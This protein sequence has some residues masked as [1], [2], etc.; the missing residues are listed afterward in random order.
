[1][2]NIIGPFAS[3]SGLGIA[4]RNIALVVA[5]RGLPPACSLLPSGSGRDRA[6]PPFPMTPPGAVDISYPNSLLIGGALPGPIG[7]QMAN[8]LKSRTRLGILAY[9]ELTELIEESIEY[10]GLADVLFAGSAF[11]RDVF[12]TY[13]PAKPCFELPCPVGALSSAGRPDRA[14]FGLPEDVPL[15]MVAFEP[16]SDLNRKNPEAAIRAFLQ[17]K[18]RG[19]A[20]LVLKLNWPPELPKD[21]TTMIFRQARELFDSA[22]QH[23]DIIGVEESLSYAD[24][25]E[26]YSCVDVIVSLH[27]SEGLGLVLLEGMLLRK[28]VIAT[29]Y[30]GNLAFMNRTYPGLVNYRLIAV[31]SPGSRYDAQYY[32]RPPVWADPDVEHASRLIERVLT[33]EDFARRLSREGEQAARSY[34]ERAERAEW[35]RHIASTGSQF[36]PRFAPPTYEGPRYAFGGQAAGRSFALPT[37]WSITGPKAAAVLGSS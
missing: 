27:R 25:L 7:I 17:C 23:P 9:W 3:E 22:R 11:T 34:V 6:V 35:I 20:K 15:V 4:A 36:N 37:S 5:R 14:R 26:L 32:A 1:M 29:A 28:P 19:K 33:D 13:F 21:T 10:L 31:E 8:A 16:G 24:A 18:S 2:I 30:S 12:R